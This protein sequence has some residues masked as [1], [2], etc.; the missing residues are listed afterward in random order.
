MNFLH[1]PQ[2]GNIHSWLEGVSSS[3][4]DRIPESCD[5][6]QRESSQ[7]SVVD[8]TDDD[9][10]RVMRQI[11]LAVSRSRGVSSLSRAVAKVLSVIRLFT[12]GDF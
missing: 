4:E 7:G 10:D 1:F 9:V 12:A 5:R 2:M 11:S 8:Y 3:L 6:S